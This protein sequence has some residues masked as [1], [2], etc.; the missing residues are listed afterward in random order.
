MRRGWRE[1][2]LDNHRRF[3]EGHSVKS[4]YFS[5]NPT[6]LIAF[7]NVGETPRGPGPSQAVGQLVTNRGRP[8]ESWRSRITSR[9]SGRPEIVRGT[10]PRAGKPLSSRPA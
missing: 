7:R 3:T 2:A 4:F 8:R 6:N 5:P 1:K 10:P 9:G